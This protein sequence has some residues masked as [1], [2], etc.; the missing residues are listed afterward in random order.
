MGGP[1]VL[2]LIMAL[3]GVIML[4]ENQARSRHMKQNDEN[5]RHQSMVDYTEHLE[6]RI[7]TLERILTDREE[8]LKREIDRL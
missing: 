5:A 6:H 3:I 8:R 4:F 2:V 7:E 1:I